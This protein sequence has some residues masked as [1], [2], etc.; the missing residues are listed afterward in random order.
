MISQK[1]VDQRN[2]EFSY[3]ILESPFYQKEFCYLPNIS[4]I[5]AK[6]KR[7]DYCDLELNQAMIELVLNF[8]YL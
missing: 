3:D 8:D 1:L 7:N 5:D 4:D 2:V 6:N